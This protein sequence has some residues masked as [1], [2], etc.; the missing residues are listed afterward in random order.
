MSK[1]SVVRPRL[2][3]FTKAMESRLALPENVAKSDWHG[4]PPHEFHRALS[5]H[6]SK[7]GT[8]CLEDNIGGV[9]KACENVANFAFIIHNLALER[10]SRNPDL[11]FMNAAPKPL[12]ARVCG[13]K[14]VTR[15]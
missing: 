8:F 5:V 9:L 12:T 7:L 1:M 14:G 3:K 2:K 4:M 6:M 10:A 11:T 13:R 15:G